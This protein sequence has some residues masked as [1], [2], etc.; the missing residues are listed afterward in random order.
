MSAPADVI[1]AGAGISGLA[2]ALAL[3]RLGLSVGVFERRRDQSEEGAGLQIGPNG[4]AILARLGVADTLR[5]YAARPAGI[6]V[7]DG[8][9]GGVLS[10]LPL[11]S[12]IEQKYGHPYWV[13]RRSHLHL[14]LLET[15]RAAGVTIESGVAVV[16]SVEDEGGV[17]VGLSDGRRLRASVLIG[18]DGLWSETRRRHFGGTGP[19]PSGRLAA[20]AVIARPSVPGI[21]ADR[22]GLWLAPGAHLVHYPL[23]AGAA[24]NLVLIAPGTVA[25]HDWAGAIEAREVMARASAFAPPARDIVAAA[26]EWRQWPLAP[27]PPL[28]SY[29]TRRVALA[30]DA[31]HAMLPFLAQGAVMALEDAEMLAAAIERMRFDWP[32]ALALYDRRR[33]PRAARVAATAARNGRIYHLSGPVRVAR[34]AVLKVIPA[35][36]L[37]AGYDWIWRETAPPAPA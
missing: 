20:R 24:H 21:E 12:G 10:E 29:A 23:D 32:A 9:S 6:V 7:R 15:T 31:A 25:S 37:V 3:R 22:I 5:S 27:L 34:N 33:R 14:A 28:T 11:G 36:L 17:S 2:V 8:L 1:V 4:T 30:G 26:A 16:S 13:L 18:C 19:V 35:P